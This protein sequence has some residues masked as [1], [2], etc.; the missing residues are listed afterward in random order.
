MLRY[1]I[2]KYLRDNWKEYDG[3][4]HEGVNELSSVCFIK[5]SLKTVTYNQI[6]QPRETAAYLINNLDMKLPEVLPWRNVKVDTRKKLNDKRK[7]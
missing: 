5:N 1:M 6:P 3:T 7:N 2:S 4:I